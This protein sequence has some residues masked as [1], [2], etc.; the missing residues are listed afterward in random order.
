MKK[1]LTVLVRIALVIFAGSI[2]LSPLFT[3]L[4]ELGEQG[5]DPR[6]YLPIVLRAGIPPTP[7]PTNT[8][9]GPTPTSSPA[10]IRLTFIEYNPPGDDVQGEYVQLT[11]VGGT[12]LDIE[13]WFIA[14][15][16]F[17]IGGE[18]DAVLH[19]PFFFSSHVLGPG[20]SVRVWTKIGIPTPT[21]VYWNAVTEIWLNFG[22]VARLYDSDSQLRHECYYD[23]GEQN[24]TC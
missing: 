4:A 15:T 10:N 2:A 24:T 13:G 1:R 23:G 22:D 12:A 20:Q 5:L 11:N 17:N 8:P 18:D 6:G 9:V 14:P 19:D 21:D 3:N 7:S 16:T